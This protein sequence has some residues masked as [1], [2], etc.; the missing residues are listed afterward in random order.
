MYPTVVRI[1]PNALKALG[2]GATA[3]YEKVKKGL[4]PPPFKLGQRACALMDTEITAINRAR[5]A[6][7]SDD[8][9]RALVVKL[10]EDRTK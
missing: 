4:L 5:A 10:V 1:H 2:F 3:F 9:I 8:E 7:D 6:G